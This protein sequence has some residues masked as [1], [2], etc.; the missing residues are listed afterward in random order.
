MAKLQK[1]KHW[2]DKNKNKKILESVQKKIDNRINIDFSDALHVMNDGKRFVFIEIENTIC[3]VTEEPV[4]E[5]SIDPLV[6]TLSKGAKG[7]KNKAKRKFFVYI[8]KF[9]LEFLEFL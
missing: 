8:R 2:V 5:C 7:H 3:K 1:D 9:G 6:I 4:E